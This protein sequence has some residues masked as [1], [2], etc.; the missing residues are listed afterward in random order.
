MEDEL[1]QLM[2]LAREHYQANEYDRAEPLL[3]QIV[4]DHRGFADMHNMLGVIHHAHSHF[5]QAQ[6]MFEEA[7]R[8]NP[9]YT[10]AALNLAV[11]YND[12][13]KYREAREVYAKA[14]ANSRSQPKQ[15]DPFARGKIANMHA[16]TADAY[17][18]L[19]LLEEAKGEYQKALVLCPT[20][21][22]IRT[23]LASTLRDS[24]DKEGAI[25]EYQAAKE[26]APKYLPAR[27]NLGV[28][29]FSVGRKEEARAEWESVLADDPGNKSC[30]MYLDI[31]GP[32]PAS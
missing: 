21:A 32:K 15:M 4:R 12:L 8:I 18:G 27:I 31:L 24:G 7:L 19:G 25:R 16:R 26:Q 1:R 9:N 23:K 28:V 6:E 2:H 14:I 3:S 30:R 22:D 11:T 29:L 20:F 5:V 13:G 17:I 10:E